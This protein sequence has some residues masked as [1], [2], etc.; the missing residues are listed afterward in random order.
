MNTRTFIIFCISALAQSSATIA[1]EPGPIPQPAPLYLHC[2]GPNPNGDLS[3]VRL[4][5]VRVRSSDIIEVAADRPCLVSSLTGRIE[6]RGDKFSVQITAKVSNS[7]GDFTGEVEL[8]KRFSPSMYSGS[9][10]HLF[11]LVLSRNSDPTP[12]L[13]EPFFKVSEYRDSKPGEGTKRK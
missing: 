6:P 7:N 9:V 10:I 5:T 2:I 12:H 8:D 13:K 1:A 4:L 3:S 11:A